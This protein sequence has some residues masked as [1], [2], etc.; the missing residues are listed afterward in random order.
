M[1]EQVIQFV[2]EISESRI[3][4]SNEMLDMRITLLEEMNRSVSPQNSSMFLKSLR[5]KMDSSDNSIFTENGLNVEAVK[6]L[7]T[8]VAKEVEKNTSKRIDE[9]LSLESDRNNNAQQLMDDIE[10]ADYKD[11]KDNIKDDDIIDL[12]KTDGINI[13]MTGAEYKKWQ[14]YVEAMY[15]EELDGPKSENPQERAE[16]QHKETITAKVVDE[17]NKR[18]KF[19]IEAGETVEVAKYQALKELNYDYTTPEGKEL[20][21]KYT[22]INA[23]HD[24][25]KIT[26][27]DVE[28]RINDGEMI[29]ITED[30]I[31]SYADQY[32]AEN[33][34]MAEM[35][36]DF[37]IAIK[38]L[39]DGIS[40]QNTNDKKGKDRRFV[41]EKLVDEAKQDLGA[42][43]AGTTKK[44]RKEII[45][46]K[47]LEKNARNEYNEA[48]KAHN[49]SLNHSSNSQNVVDT[50]SEYI[51]AKRNYMTISRNLE[52]TLSENSKTKLIEYN[53]KEDSRLIIAKDIVE[54]YLNGEKSLCELY[55]EI[56]TKILDENN[57]IFEDVIHVLKDR[58]LMDPE[59]NT[60]TSLETVDAEH[61]LDS[62]QRELAALEKFMNQNRENNSI[63]R[64]EILKT[65]KKIVNLKFKIEND[66]KIAN[67]GKEIFS[68]TSK[69]RKDSDSYNKTQENDYV[70]RIELAKKSRFKLDEY[71][72][73]QNS[74]IED[75]N[76]IKLICKKDGVSEQEAA[77]L[78]FKDNPEL[79][80][81]YSQNFKNLFND[82][83]NGSKFKLTIMDDIIKYHNSELTDDLEM[84]KIKLVKDYDTYIINSSNSD[85]YINKKL[86]I[87]EIE[88]YLAKAEYINRYLNEGKNAYLV[89]REERI[90]AIV[91]L[92]FNSNESALD[93]YNKCEDVKDIDMNELI[94]RIAQRADEKNPGSGIE[95]LNLERGYIE[96]FY[97][98]DVNEKHIKCTRGTQ[99]DEKLWRSEVA[100]ATTEMNLKKTSI[101]DLKQQ[102]LKND[103]QTNEQ[104]ENRDELESMLKLRKVGSV[105]VTRIIIKER[106]TSQEL[107]EQI[108]LIIEAGKDEQ[109]SVKGDA[110]DRVF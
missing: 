81:K 5:E 86:E 1:E 82:K 70:G 63:S 64:R 107:A 55:N 12:T 26:F 31:D 68:K 8:S 72:K 3:M 37:K 10:N 44:A 7:V 30:L 41:D 60:K 84:Q 32:I 51:V 61:R 11:N 104:L 56:D 108:G 67:R 40:K 33:P 100:N 23:M 24:I 65:E 78:Y 96:N 43:Y 110:E 16:R 89:K 98:K 2:E 101:N 34:F 15:D 88:S 91:G 97:K 22:E 48:K 59:N 58:M 106:V 35:K 94:K 49:D 14:N 6:T 54:R 29:E 46:R 42:L 71:V 99:A 4:T 80:S 69:C 19:L 13:K 9:E 20:F 50:E 93:I 76:K 39:L 62:E 36:S 52:K 17:Y 45:R 102:Y 109:E 57:M 47:K 92:Y 53:R 75:R 105:E 66:K 74:L 103:I 27:E 21:D 90:N 79:L 87:N 95:I 18:V 73:F 28:K 85:E 83:E 25:A 77:Q 38:A